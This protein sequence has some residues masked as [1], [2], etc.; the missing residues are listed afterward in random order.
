MKR[1]KILIKITLTA[2]QTIFHEFF[3]GATINSHQHSPIYNKVLLLLFAYIWIYLLTL[4]YRIRM[5]IA[6]DNP[7]PMQFSTGS[8]IIIPS[9]DQGQ[10]L[11][12]YE[13]ATQA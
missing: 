8:L 5:T 4:C 12:N 7:N 10:S 1:R 9:H 6:N 11:K 13:G 2:L 3:W